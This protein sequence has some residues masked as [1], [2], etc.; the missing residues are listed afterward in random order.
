MTLFNLLNYCELPWWLFWLLP[1]LLG[2]LLGWLIWSRRKQSD[3]DNSEEILVLKK[4]IEDLKEKLKSCKDRNIAL[5][6]EI[7]KLKGDL[8]KR[9][10]TPQISV[11]PKVSSSL[12]ALSGVSMGM[13]TDY[14]EYISAD[15]FQI[16]E[17]IGPVMESVLKENGA[18][19]FHDLAKL[20][21]SEIRT[22]LN[23]YGDKYA[24]I[25][26]KTWPQQAD[27]AKDKKWEELITL[28]K[29]LVG[30]KV[31]VHT[32]PE[33]FSKLEKFLIKKGVIKTWKPDDLKVVE[34]IGPKIETLL[35]DAGIND[36]KALSETSVERINS[37]LE[38]AGP[39]FQLAKP[40]TWPKQAGLAAAGKWK[41]L[42]ELKD[43]LI[44]GRDK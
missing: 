7:G 6:S 4:E 32:G 38:E 29:Q 1:F 39:R 14:S 31:G 30:G 21:E 19:E 20:N 15:N 43:V 18:A 40:D 28:Q 10:N 11:D 41:E 27:L 33:A 2:L 42:N 16:I 22:I 35:K 25:D 37:I 12:G 34:G 44:G 17:G 36:W 26:P 9:I 24:I 23:K 3:E 8:E 13:A 5:E